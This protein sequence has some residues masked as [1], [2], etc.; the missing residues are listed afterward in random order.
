LRDSLYRFSFSRFR[1]WHPSRRTYHRR[2]NRNASQTLW[3]SFAFCQMVYLHVPQRSVRAS[4][5]ALRV[6]PLHAF[7]GPMLLRRCPQERVRPFSCFTAPAFLD[8]LTPVQT[9]RLTFG[10]TSTPKLS[11]RVLNVRLRRRAVPMSHSH[12][13]WKA[14]WRLIRPLP[15]QTSTLRDNDSRRHAMISG[16]SLVAC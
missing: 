5:L 11:Y 14:E 2:L 16:V 10:R 9:T 8:W 1:R 4:T 6:R 12:A 13:E 7:Q 15:Q 3:V